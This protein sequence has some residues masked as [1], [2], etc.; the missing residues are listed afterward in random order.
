MTCAGTGLGRVVQLLA[1]HTGVL[2]L[3]RAHTAA[4]EAVK[5]VSQLSVQV[6]PGFWPVQ[7]TK[8]PLLGLAGAVKHRFSAG[9]PDNAGERLPATIAGR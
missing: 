2:Q 6:L 9:T 8:L 3:P 7:F 1:M 4:P 5:P